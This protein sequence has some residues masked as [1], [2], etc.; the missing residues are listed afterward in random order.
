[1]VLEGN[2]EFSWVQEQDVDEITALFSR[3]FGRPMVPEYYRWQFRHQEYGGFRSAC[4]RVGG[5][6]V[7][8][9]G[10]SPREWLIGGSVGLVMAKHTSMTHPGSVGLGLYSRLL[11]WANPRLAETGADMIL[12]WPNRF[13]HPMQR[14]RTSY[15][16]VYQIPMMK[17]MPG[18]DPS[19]T[20]SSIPLTETRLF[21]FDE[22]GDLAGKTP[23]RCLFSNVRTLRYLTWRYTQ[24]PDT[25]YY[26]IENRRGGS[27]RSVVVFK[28]YPAREP[29][30]IN[31]L[32]WLRDPESLEADHAL[33]QME[34][35]AATMGLPV[36]LWHNVHDYPRH[37]VL[38]RRGYVPSDPIFYFGVIPLS[39]SEK[40]GAY[41]DWRNWYMTMGDVDV[42]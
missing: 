27:V 1:M 40:L 8:H 29:H 25:T 5:R 6:L 38:E 26:A 31:V 42:F 36:T 20:P 7:S 28:L 11:E 10:F 23:G 12:S 9:A 19:S 39:D 22:W 14:N 41:R 2:I 30:V 35:L 21:N 33:D 18:G 17:R 4:A 3:V 13:S 15:E 16:D 24:R 34:D 37:H 32:E